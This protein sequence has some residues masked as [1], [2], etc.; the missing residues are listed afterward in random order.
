MLQYTIQHLLFIKQT[1]EGPALSPE[2]PPVINNDSVP[3]I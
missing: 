2:E 3:N 1:K